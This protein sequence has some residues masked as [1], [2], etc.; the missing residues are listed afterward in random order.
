MEYCEELN[1]NI[2]NNNNNNNYNNKH[3]QFS[4][5]KPLRHTSVFGCQVQLFYY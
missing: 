5:S 2:N 1:N 4:I 3:L